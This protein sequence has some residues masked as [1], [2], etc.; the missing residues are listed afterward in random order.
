MEAGVAL[1]SNARF[2]SSRVRSRSLSCGVSAGKA[3]VYT[4]RVTDFGLFLKIEDVDFLE[5]SFQSEEEGG[6]V[7]LKCSLRILG[8]LA[9]RSDSMGG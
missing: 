2:L 6:L 7:R 3:A 5:L 4:Q 8:R 1:D 9:F